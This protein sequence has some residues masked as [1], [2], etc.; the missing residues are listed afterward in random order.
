MLVAVGPIEVPHGAEHPLRLRVED[1]GTPHIDALRVAQFEVAREVEHIVEGRER[2]HV[3]HLGSALGKHS[4]GELLHLAV[5]RLFIARRRFFAVSFDIVVEL[6][7]FEI[8]GQ[9]VGA[10]ALGVAVVSVP[11]E[12]RRLRLIVYRH[13]V[14][15]QTHL[16]A[17]VVKAAV[18]AVDVEFHR[19]HVVGVA[20]AHELGG[21]HGDGVVQL[22]IAEE[23]GQQHPAFSLGQSEGTL[24]FVELKAEGLF[25]HRPRGVAAPA[26]FGRIGD[27]FPDSGG[28]D[29]DLRA[30]PRFFTA[31]EVGKRD[32]VGQFNVDARHFSLCRGRKH[33]E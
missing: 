3:D 4:A 15:R 26:H 27:V 2:R 19:N 12:E 21:A 23:V 14:G 1:V 24:L 30:A 6:G 29:G 11:F 17:Q 8:D 25:L 32:A 5:E 9:L 28:R 33:G 10:V 13:A 18:G 20:G 16:F 31:F 22:R 7:G